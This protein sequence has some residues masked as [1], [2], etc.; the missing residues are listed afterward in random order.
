MIGFKKI[1]RYVC[2]LLAL[3]M[4]I[5]FFTAPTQVL[6]DEPESNPDYISTLER[7]RDILNV[8][9]TR[10]H[11]SE[12]M[13]ENANLPRP[14]SHYI[15]EAADYVL[16]EGM[17]PIIL[18]DF[19]GVAGTSL[20]TDE[21]GLI[22]WEVHV[23]QS[24]LYNIS[25]QYYSYEGKSSD[26]Q[27]AIFINGE[28]PFFE[29]NQVEF[30]RTWVNQLPYIRRDNRDNDLR[31]VQVEYHTWRHAFV[32]DSL[33][34]YNEPFSFYLQQGRNTIGFYSLREPMVIRQLHVHQAPE[35]LP[36]SQ[37]IAAFGNTPTPQIGVIRVEG[38]EANRRSSP[39]LAPQADNSGPGVEPY[40]P[41]A[42]RINHIG[43]DSWAEP[44]SWI[45]WD[46]YVP[47]EG[48]YNI[49]LNVRQHFTR[50]TST[51]R[52]ITIN[53]EVPFAEM[54]AVAFPFDT[55]WRVEVLGD[56]SE[57]YM[58][59]LNAGMN[60]IKI[61]AMLGDYA[62]YYRE[63]QDAVL[64]LNNLYRQ[65]IM[66]VGLSP[67][68]FRDYRIG[69][70]L[71]HLEGEL[72]R[73]RERLDYI[74]ARLNYLADGRGERDAVINNLSV[75]ITR[76]YSNI[77]NIPR[78]IHD[79]RINI[80][81][82]GTWLMQVR[83]QRLAVGEIYII[84][85]GEAM[86]TL[87]NGFFA[88]LWH[89]IQ[90]LFFSFFI[91]YNTIGDVVEG[92]DAST[93][94]VWL[95]T[96][97]D[98]ANVIRGMM[99]ESFTRDHD[100]NINLML[101][102][103]AT[104]LPATLS[105][106]GP[107]VTLMLGQDLPMNFGMRGAAMN[108]AQFPEFNEVTQRFSEAAM[109]PFTF[110]G[111]TF[112][113][114]ETLTF[115]MLFYRRD[116]LYELGLDPPDTWDD[117]RASMSVL[118]QHHMEFGLP[119]EAGGFNITDMTFA[120]FLFQNGGDFYNADGSLSALDSDISLTAFRDFA[121]YFTDY[122]LPVVY[123]FANRF[124]AG[125][126]P[127]AVADYTNY[128]MLQVFAPEI[129][130]LWGFRPIPGTVQPDGSIN[131]AVATGGS[132]VVM[133]S[134]AEDPLASWEFMK[135]W[136]SAD[137][138]VQFGRGMESLMGAAARHPT[139]NLEAFSQMPWPLRDY[140]NLGAQFAHARGIPQVPGG[141]FTPRQIRNAFYTA[142]VQQTVGPREALTEF[143]R[144]INDEIRAKRIEFGLDV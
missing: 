29:A 42:I 40:S 54:E 98:Q 21:M 109:T 79:F 18:Q 101:V 72:R 88:Q 100:I 10:F 25:I 36:Y 73:E 63:I 105:G 141:Y 128:N 51:F 140:E 85:V 9:G 5:P 90:T 78:R 22:E 37:A 13:A 70:R 111:M 117:V 50:G 138:Q 32:R 23:A 46:F 130:G 28:Q 135:W 82:L 19:E 66:I 113:L 137:V 49:A 118:A 35:I 142:T 144:L 34:A 110:D 61:E 134:A 24:G 17:V 114:P 26:I 126:M 56:G 71:P 125:D 97:R 53:G 132:A 93:V 6:A 94:T 44:G 139:A 43:G 75:L 122:R 123:D 116:V 65:I 76:L 20:W 119:L 62:H 48:L 16:A 103:I 80:G 58:F 45:E 106:Q 38:Q 60:T 59:W 136:T 129:R 96:G 131:R 67:D 95:G 107:D 30:P 14:D 127:I 15:I 102:D 1:K 89:E 4:S 91:D 31:P 52:R 2:I 55:G 47:Q 124:R 133:M 83:E 108:L 120:M 7:Y 12:Y 99:D 69:T 68:I 74:Y 39:M 87:N 57:P 115:N 8:F 86:P 104:L 41:R 92:D 112:A 3:T 33:G 77:E 11:F 27:R 64:N 81:S 143:V 84:S 121:R